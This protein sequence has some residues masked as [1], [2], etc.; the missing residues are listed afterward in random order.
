MRVSTLTSRE[1]VYNAPTIPWNN[2]TYTPVSNKLIM[3]LIE[4]KLSQNGL[5]IK[6]QEYRTART[7]NGLI[8]GVI[9]G[10]NITTGDG[11]FG[12]RV[13]FRNSYDKS[14][15]FAIVC[16]TLVFICENGA[17]SG[18][19]QYKRIHRGVIRDDNSSTTIDDVQDYI[20]GGI[21]ALQNSFEH[22]VEQLKELKHFEVSPKEAYNILGELFFKQE[23]VTIN[24]MSVIKKELQFSQNFKHLGDKDFTAYDLYN[25]V[26]ESLKKSH[27]SSYV[28]DHIATHK[29]FETV[30]GI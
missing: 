26:T 18:E 15:S 24:Q 10:Y 11:E 1:D 3:D 14:M 7:E 17:I 29:L 28:Q 22:T 6:N 25:H 12:Q 20:I 9:G 5:I 16:G 21:G 13:M 19:Y 8:K 27:V 30:F 23:V 4:D 2:G